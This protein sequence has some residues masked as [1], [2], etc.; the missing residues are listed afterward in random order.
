MY[1]RPGPSS[2][3]TQ[4]VTIVVEPKQSVWERLNI[5]QYGQIDIRSTRH[6]D[7]AMVPNI[8]DA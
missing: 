5:N 1:D 2:F 4:T 8:G 7:P 6:A 3:T